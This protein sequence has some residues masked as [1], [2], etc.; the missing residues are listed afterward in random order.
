[1]RTILLAI[2]C[3][4]SLSA[5]DPL[6][7]RIRHNDPATYRPSAGPHGGAGQMNFFGMFDAKDFNANL[8]FMHRGVILPKSGIG[9]HFHN[10]MEEMFVI[11]NGEAEFTID[12][13]TSPI[14]GPAGAP[15]R[16]GHSHAIYN[17]TD[18]PVE[19]MNIGVGSIKSKYDN[20]DLG[21]ARVGAPLDNP[22]V[23]MAMRLYLELLRPASGLNGGKGVARYRRALPPEVFLTPWAYVDHVLLPAGASIGRHRHA[24][25]E[26][27]YYVMEGAGMASVNDESAPIRKGDALPVL[28]GDVHSIE[29]TSGGDLELMVVG[30]AMEKGKIDVVNVQ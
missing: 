25:V 20:F 18:Q 27:I 22:P 12:G 17:P 14:K 8:I 10:Q 3:A 15:C 23:F 21:D 28:I 30:V 26:E 7:Q 13:R 4:L 19:W 16:M 1:M 11:L 24:G 5:R 6:S 2:V 9:H 29:N